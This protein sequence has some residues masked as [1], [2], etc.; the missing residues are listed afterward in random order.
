VLSFPVLFESIIFF[1]SV[2]LSFEDVSGLRRVMFPSPLGLSGPMEIFIRP[3]RQASVFLDSVIQVSFGFKVSPCRRRWFVIFLRRPFF[4]LAS[5][6]Q[7]LNFFL[8]GV[9]DR[10]RVV[11]MVDSSAIP[12][13]SPWSPPGLPSRFVPLCIS[14]FFLEDI[15]V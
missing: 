11:R 14:V 13:F 3:L 15:H 7:P 5:D 9:V 2:F 1:F 4:F 8:S 10:R 6:L 12:S